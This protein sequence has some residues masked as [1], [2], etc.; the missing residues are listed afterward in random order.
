MIVASGACWS[1]CAVHRAEP[2]RKPLWFSTGVVVYLDDTVEALIE[3]PVRADAL[4]SL[5]ISLWPFPPT[6]L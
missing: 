2:S 1:L 4:D 6:D 3:E 5:T